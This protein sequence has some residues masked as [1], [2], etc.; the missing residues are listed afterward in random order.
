M[1]LNK[2]VADGL[3]GTLLHGRKRS[4]YEVFREDFFD[5]RAIGFGAF[6]RLYPLG[7][8]AKC[9]PGFFHGCFVAVAH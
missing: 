3:M 4:G 7:V 2:G 6:A 8:G 1:I 9:S 5:N